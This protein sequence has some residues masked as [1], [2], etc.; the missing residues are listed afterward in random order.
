MVLTGR[1]VPAKE[2]AAMGLCNRLVGIDGNEEA[3]KGLALEA[4]LQLAE[5]ICN[6]G[7]LAVRAA[8][9]ALTYSCEAV[10][11]AA[12]DSV[13]MTKDRNA[14]LEAFSEKRKPILIGE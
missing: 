12:Y 9:S 7:P 14:A 2:A 8:I 11:N 4:G 1:S 3:Q 13:L 5:N 6:A 10:E